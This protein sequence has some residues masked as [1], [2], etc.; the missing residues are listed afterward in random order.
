[1]QHS[2]FQV[3]G[4][5]CEVLQFRVH[6]MVLFFMA[7]DG[8]HGGDLCYQN[9]WADMDVAL[10][11]CCCIRDAADTFSGAGDAGRSRH[12]LTAHAEL[13]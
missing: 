3:A 5:C 9:L 4:T 1:M 13:F 6:E 10:A 8:A 12:M 11:T 2:A 7:N